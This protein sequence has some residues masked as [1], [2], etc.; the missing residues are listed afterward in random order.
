[1]ISSS[2]YG[3]VAKN[4]S[5]LVLGVLPSNRVS[6]TVLF[7]DDYFLTICV[8]VIIVISCHRAAAGIV[9]ELQRFFDEPIVTEIQPFEVF[10]KAEDNHQNYYDRNS[11]GGYCQSVINPKLANLRK[12]FEEKLKK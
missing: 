10:Y 4:R 1:M 9:E 11:N 7:Y 3:P 8:F 12:L 2:K 5:F 6:V